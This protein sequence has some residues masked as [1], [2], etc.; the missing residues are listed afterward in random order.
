MESDGA[1]YSALLFTRR[2]GYPLFQPQLYD[3]LPDERMR[4]GV[5]IGDV[6]IVTRPGG[7]DPIFNI[8]HDA[9]D[10]VVN[11]WGVP[12]DFGRLRLDDRDIAWQQLRYPAGS[13][14]SNSAINKRRVAAG[15]G[16][17]ADFGANVEVST[18]SKRNAILLL[19][20]GA[21]SWDL[22]SLHLF[23]HYA[24][25]HTRNWYKFVNMTLQR[26]IANGD[27]YLVTGVTKSS[28]WSVAAIDQGTDGDTQ[29]SMKLKAAQVVTANASYSWSWE[30]TSSGSRHSGP[31]GR[32]ALEQWT[33]N[34]TVFLRGYKTYLRLPQMARFPRAISVADSDWSNVHWRGVTT[35]YS[36][37]SRWG[38][39]NDTTSSGTGASGSDTSPQSSSGQQLSSETLSAVLE[40]A[41]S[42]D[43]VD[44]VS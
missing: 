39:G 37:S 1:L 10:N 16:V 28:S 5:C 7:F 13:D 25:K 4:N 19:P 36:S 40:E 18:N 31:R 24:E 17:N 11:P 6:G 3:D 33:D 23:K 29:L 21:S 43:Y 22:R 20:D 27:L 30:E 35:P 42:N 12:E 9:G 38:G 41:D 15:A 2:Q 8:L 34:Q 32:Q 44:V 26:G 14:V